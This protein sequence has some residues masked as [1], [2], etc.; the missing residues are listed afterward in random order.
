MWRLLVLFT[1]LLFTNN[2]LAER[3][4][5]YLTMNDAILIARYSSPESVRVKV[6]YQTKLW[7]REIF[8]SSLKPQLV[9][10][11]TLP[12]LERKVGEV[13]Q[14]DGTV[15]F[16][17]YANSS[18]QTSLSVEQAIPLTGG[19]LSIGSEL[20]RYDN[21]E[22]KAHSYAAYPINI[23]LRQPIM[24]YNSLKWGKKIDPIKLEEINREYARNIELS[25][26]RTLNLFYSLIQHQINLQIAESNLKINQHLYNIAKERYQMGRI[27]Q[28]EL[29]S[30]ELNFLK[31]KNQQ[32]T[33]QEYKR[34]S[35]IELLIY[36]G[37]PISSELVLVE[38]NIPQK[39]NLELGKIVELSR[40]NSYHEALNRRKL[41][42]AEAGIAEAKAKAGVSA[43]LNLIMGWSGS[44]DNLNQM[45]FSSGD[46]QEVYF[47]LTIP[48]LDWGKGRSRVKTAI[49]TRKMVQLNIDQESV[50]LEHE[51]I[52]L[53]EQ[54]NLLSSKVENTKLIDSLAQVRFNIDA[55]RYVSQNISFTDFSIAQQEKD[56]AKSAYI[57]CLQEYWIALY[58][59][60]ELTLY[61]FENNI[62]LVAILSNSN[63]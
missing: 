62:S 2:A 1:Y 16:V 33:T 21:I 53:F 61:D 42:E 11:T 39:M 4:T 37:I 54:I 18:L 58:R 26:Q 49:E 55:Q 24:G 6:E 30:V 14:S 28:S 15:K 43:Q 8:L 45:D 38:P 31:S 5:V 40:K 12:Q 20:L 36:L 59:L 22:S 48:I 63:I 25:I 35:Q 46:R 13:P 27:S 51:A 57:S 19:T 9:L 44:S 3:D 41:M 60:R 29:I 56:I 50:A 47:G 34:K 52:L 32:V 23:A 17:R 10:N 7:E